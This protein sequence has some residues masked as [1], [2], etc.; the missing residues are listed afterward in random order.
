MLV[1]ESDRAAMKGCDVTKMAKES[2]V[3]II[4]EIGEGC[5]KLRR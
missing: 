5:V 1:S 3:P 2:A 4:E